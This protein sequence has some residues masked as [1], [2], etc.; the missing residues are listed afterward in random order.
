MT[1]RRTILKDWARKVPD[2]LSTEVLAKIDKEIEAADVAKP[3]RPED[4]PPPGDMGDDEM[5]DGSDPDAMPAGRMGG[6]KMTR[7]LTGAQDKE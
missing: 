4:A 5:P 2:G 6:K 7:A 1:H 3:E